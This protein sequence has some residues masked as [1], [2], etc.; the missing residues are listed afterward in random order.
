MLKPTRGGGVEFFVSD[1]SVVVDDVVF[2]TS[3]HEDRFCVCC[4]TVVFTEELFSH[5]GVNTLFKSGV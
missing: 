4:R 2:I 5:D 1:F 3:C